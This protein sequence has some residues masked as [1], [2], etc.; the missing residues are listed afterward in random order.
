V[1]IHEI[2]VYSLSQK[3]YLAPFLRYGRLLVHFLLSTNEVPLFN[4]LV[5][6]AKFRTGRSGHKKLETT[7]YHQV[8]SIF[9]Y[10]ENHVNVNHE[11]D[12]Q[13][14]RLAH[15]ICHDSLHCVAKSE[16]RQNGQWSTSM[17]CELKMWTILTMHWPLPL[18]GC[19]RPPAH[20]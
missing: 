7:I 6:G 2:W 1:N 11:C 10:Q 12:K 16:R 9:R 4:I 17:M 8:Q 19:T 20:S 15:S 18:H 14:D 3:N 5:Q 13:T